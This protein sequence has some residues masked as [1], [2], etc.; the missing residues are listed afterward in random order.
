M[1]FFRLRHQTKIDEEYWR[2]FYKGYPLQQYMTIC[3]FIR[4]ILFLSQLFSKFT[5]LSSHSNNLCDEPIPIAKLKNGFWM[6]LN[7]GKF[8]WIEFKLSIQIFKQSWKYRN[9]SA[10]IKKGVPSNILRGFEY[11]ELVKIHFFRICTPGPES[12]V[13]FQHNGI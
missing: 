10:W 8:E 12:Y 2:I 6:S 1:L 3:C 11:I 5:V 13:S 7:S 9:R 4:L